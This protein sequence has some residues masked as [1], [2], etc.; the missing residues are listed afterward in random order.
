MDSGP[1]DQR[2]LIP[3]LRYTIKVVSLTVVLGLQ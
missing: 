1:P 2:R 3:F